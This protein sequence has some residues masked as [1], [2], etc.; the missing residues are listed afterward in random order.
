MYE[1][2]TRPQKPSAKKLIFAGL[3]FAFTLITSSIILIF[4]PFASKEKADYFKGDHPILFMGK[5]AGNAYI[6]GETIYLPLTFLQEFIDE[7]MIFDEHSQSIIIATK[8]KVAQMPSESSTYYVNDKPVKLDFSAVKQ[9]EGDRY[10]AIEPLLVFYPITYSLLSDTNAVWVQKNGE[11][12]VA[13]KV[14]EKEIHEELLRLRTKASLDSPYTASVAP[15]ENVF[16]EQEK[17]DYYFIRKEDG[18]AGFLKKK[19]IKKGERKEI[20]ISLE[21][22]KNTVPKME[23]PIQLTWEAVYTKNP[24]TSSIPKM[25]GVNV[26]SP[27]WFELADGKGNIK[28]LGSKDYAKWARKQGYQ[29][30]GLFSNAF[31][32]ELTHEA[33]GSFETRQNMIRQL[34][35]F[36]QLYELNGIN[37]DIENVNP[38]DGPFITQF[39]RE[40]TPYFHDAGLVVSM[41]ITFISS[42]GNWSAFYERDK[43]AGIADYM[44][45]MA[46]DEHWGSSQVA[47]SVASLPWVEEN[48]KLLLEVVPNEKLILGVPLYTRLWEQKSNGDVSS[49]ALSMG[50]VKEWLS[51][52]K[53]TPVYD[54]VSGQNY[55]EHYSEKDKITYRVWLEDEIS[56][57]KRAELAKK[58]NLAGVASWSR[59]FADETAW[60]ALTL[61]NKEAAK[62]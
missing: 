42:S 23:G 52:N 33:F 15:K 39:V 54:P 35:H 16:I 14:Q 51:Q 1:I 38:A 50:K 20:A 30:W 21:E 19:Y 7:A 40:A 27:T 61:T 10:L 36:S 62:K 44:V 47:G 6:E 34:L 43:L 24:N 26:I 31:D 48:L 4:Y 37:L 49:K 2:E 11:T 57:S 55:A 22:T 5:Q 59:Y 45:V 60:S 32:P 41:D 58:Y 56:L 8:N 46:Y 25:P 13:G 18:T 12:M 17:E 28:N 53:I 9:I 3:L 29:I